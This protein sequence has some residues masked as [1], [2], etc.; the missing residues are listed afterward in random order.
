MKSPLDDPARIEALRTSGLLHRPQEAAFD[1]LTAL[2]ARV[3]NAPCA[4]ISLVDS[5]WVYYKSHTGLPEPAASEGQSLDCSICQYV[6]RRGRALSVA[7]TREDPDMCTSRAVTEQGCHAFL[8][9]PLYAAGGEILGALCVVDHHPR[10][11]QNSELDTLTDFGGALTAEIALKVEISQRRSVEAELRKSESRFRNL[12]EHSIDLVWELDLAGHVLYVNNAS[13][14]VLGVEPGSLIGENLFTMMLEKSAAQEVLDTRLREGKGFRG[15]KTSLRRTDGRVTHLESSG[16]PL[17]DK[18]QRIVSIVG[19]SRDTSAKDK[20][21]GF[22]REVVRSNTE[23]LSRTNR[24]LRQAQRLARLGNW[25]W[26]GPARPLVWRE[27][28]SELFGEEACREI[29]SLE[30]LLDRIDYD[31]RPGLTQA[32]ADCLSNEQPLDYRFQL[33]LSDRKPM[34]LRAMAEW[35]QTVD[36]APAMLGTFQDLT[37]EEALQSQLRQSQKMDAVGRLA[38]GIAHDFNNLLCGMIGFGEFAEMELTPDHPALADVQEVVAT[39]HRAARLTT[40]LLLFSSRSNGTVADIEVNAAV[41]QL[42]RMLQRLIGHGIVYTNELGESIGNVQMDRSGFEQVLVNLVV[43]ARD[44]MAGVGRLTVRTRDERVNERLTSHFQTLSGEYTV[45]EVTDSGSGI[46]NAVLPQIF[47]PFFTTK[48]AG[49]GTGLGLSVCFGIVEQAGGAIDVSTSASGTTFAV[50]LP[51][52]DDLLEDLD[53]AVNLSSDL[54]AGKGE[55]I[56]VVDIEELVL[57]ILERVLVALNYKVLTFGSPEELLDKLPELPAP[58]LLI[59]EYVLPKISGSE[60]SRRVANFYPQM[61][62]L[63]MCADL[64]P[65]LAAEDSILVKPFGRERLVSAVRQ[66][67]DRT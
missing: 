39:A 51:K 1:R 22:L 63:V 36:A 15:L 40:Q 6:V 59:T 32:M 26:H 52:R 27:G 19:T 56:L 24:G 66:T 64:P 58:A 16:F 28:A 62:T 8:G 31:S 47:E 61:S 54:P 25:T 17:V 35:V 42:S 49:R 12:V 57:K 48:A 30:K 4:F 14:E 43:N 41:E 53:S 46:P 55:V 20:M 11:W 2:T 21:D 37:D 7:D 13:V 38:G 18:D 3:L 60:L 44:A 23:E 5:D 29:D 65:D 45:I 33:S 9:V 50:Y 10:S 67:L 34:M